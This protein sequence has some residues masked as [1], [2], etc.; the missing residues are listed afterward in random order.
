MAPIFLVFAIF[1][2]ALLQQ[3]ILNLDRILIGLELLGLTFLIQGL[4]MGLFP[5]GENMVP[6]LT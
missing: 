4:Q 5:I 1:Q 6:A 3:P 2:L